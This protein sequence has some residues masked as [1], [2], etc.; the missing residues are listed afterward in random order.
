MASLP[1]RSLGI[2]RLERGLPPG[3]APWMLPPGYLLNPATFD[4]EVIWETVE[5]AWADVV[6]RGDR[7]LEPACTA[8]AKRLVER[9]AVAITS[10][11]GFFIRH[12]AAVAASAN[13]PVA[14]SSLLLVPA[15]L[16]QLSPTA[17]LAVLT[18]D[19][20]YLAEDMLGL[21]NPKDR[22]RVVIAGVE[23]GTLWRNELQRPPPPTEV[24]DIEKD[25]VDCVL[26]IRAAHP[27]I[28]A[29]LFECTA[30]PCV[31]PA[32]RHM[33][34]LPIYDITTLCRMTMSTVV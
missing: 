5:G 24:S 1:P 34:G 22:A 20:T 25:V 2:L 23:G 6:I 11:C 19:S 31:A 12:Q 18:A 13:V 15:L 4:F 28:A 8:A 3:A 27:E 30:F 17:K 33:T 7:G 10:S 32:I 29:I 9:G 14:T 16:R 26:Q 21:D